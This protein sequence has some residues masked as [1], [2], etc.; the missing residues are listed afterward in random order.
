MYIF[1]RAEFTPKLFLPEKNTGR[2][3]NCP[4]VHNKLKVIKYIS[5]IQ[6][7]ILIEFFYSIVDVCVHFKKALKYFLYCT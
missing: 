4:M 7:L 5:D 3:H 6:H 2:V 1:I